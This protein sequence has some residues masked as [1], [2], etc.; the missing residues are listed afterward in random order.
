MKIAQFKL[1]LDSKLPTIRGSR[2]CKL[3]HNGAVYFS[4][5][6]TP[7]AACCLQRTCC[8]RQQPTHLASLR[9]LLLHGALANAT[10]SSADLSSAPD[11]ATAA[12]EECG[13]VQVTAFARVARARSRVASSFSKGT[14]C[15]THAHS[16]LALAR[17]SSAWSRCFR[18]IRARTRSTRFRI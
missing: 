17:V 14:H 2:Q 1:E 15:R 3:P 12:T 10:T 11:T 16:H 4:K 9:K 13:Q 7:S 6:F 18:D 8:P 5:T